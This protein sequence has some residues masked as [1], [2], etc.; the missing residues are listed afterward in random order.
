[1]KIS[2]N[3]IQN[4]NRKFKKRILIAYG[5]DRDK[6]LKKHISSKEPTVLLSPSMSE[7]VDL[8]GNL[9][10]FQKFSIF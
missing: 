5:E 1:M 3:I 6:M 7:G 10:K 9:S 2:K 8:K 4:V